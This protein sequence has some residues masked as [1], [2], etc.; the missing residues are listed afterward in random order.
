MVTGTRAWRREP[1]EIQSEGI[2]AEGKYEQKHD[3]KPELSPARKT[4]AGG[5]GHSQEVCWEFEPG[6][7]NK[8]GDGVVVGFSVCKVIRY[9]EGRQGVWELVKGKAGE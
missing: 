6:L 9:S 5:S 1:D 8:E 2:R 3:M 7:Q 4:R